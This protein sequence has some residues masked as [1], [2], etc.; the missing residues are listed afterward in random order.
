MLRPGYAAPPP[1]PPHNAPFSDLLRPR[2]CV[3]WAGKKFLFSSL[4]Q[5]SIREEKCWMFDLARPALIHISVAWV[6]RML[7]G[8][9]G[10]GPHLLLPRLTWW[11]VNWCVRLPPCFCAGFIRPNGSNW[12]RCFH[13]GRSLLCLWTGVRCPLSSNLEI[14]GKY[15]ISLCIRHTIFRK[16]WGLKTGC[17]VKISTMSA[18]TR[19][20]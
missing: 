13:F 15:C 6:K 16:F 17:V 3:S 12:T 2:P 7:G 4:C 5:D 9:W 14:R 8:I 20:K 10:R 19:V 18:K 1:T 11:G